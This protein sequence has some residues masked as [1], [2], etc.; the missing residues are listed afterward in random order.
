MGARSRIA[1]LVV[2]A[3]AL[4][5]CGQST[6]STT[7]KASTSSGPKS[8][9]SVPVSAGALSMGPLQPNG[10]VAVLAGTS[11]S[12]GVFFYDL[13]S[14]KEVGSFSVSNLATAVT[15]LP[16]GVVA[17][18]LGNS[19]VGAVDLDTTSGQQ[20]ASIPVAAPVRGLALGTNGN[21]IDVLVGT[22]TTRA[23]VVLDVTTRLATTTIPVSANTVAIA[24]STSGTELYGL[25]ANGFVDVYAMTTGQ[26]IGTFPVGHSGIDLVASPDGSAL[27]VLKG[28]GGIR[29]VAVVNLA[30]EGDVRALPAPADSVAI[31]TDL[32]GTHLLELVGGSAAN[33]QEWPVS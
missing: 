8:T 2:V 17:V 12:K 29:N 19:R 16:S 30:T 21:S 33:I 23:V 14:G 10:E 11:N 9:A 20:L 13:A 22:S 4:A 5:A 24:P 32:S 6:T 25:D 31:E 18:G 7:S 1:A 27:Y 28:V 3:S 26:K 15:E